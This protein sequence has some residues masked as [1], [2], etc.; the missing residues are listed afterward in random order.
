M[1]FRP[2][3]LGLAAA[4]CT[5]AG[6][7]D[8]TLT[9]P[10]GGS[11]VIQSAPATPGLRVAPGPQV[12]L[13]GLP[14]AA[15]YGTPVCHDA[16]GTLGRCSAGAI[17]TPGP[18]GPAG[19]VGSPGPIGPPG[20][21]GPAGSPGPQ[22]TVGPAGPQGPVGPAG[23]QGAVGPAGPP[24]AQG[25]AGSGIT[26]LTEARH[27]C[28]S[29]AGAVITGSGYSVT[30]AGSQYTVSFSPALAGAPISLLLDARASNGR[31]LAM[32]GVTTAA[33]AVLNVGWLEATES[34]ASICF[35]AAR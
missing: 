29:G 17:G 32:G 31:S 26:G 11:V 18:T 28:F 7:A 34:V 2:C 27:G 33:N 24:G 30:R 5:R 4:L 10:P 12:Q 16:G 25:P 19:P 23:A 14:A 22:G 9:P 8:V 1:T 15:E 6:A 3:L 21:P 35:L 20:P 13:P